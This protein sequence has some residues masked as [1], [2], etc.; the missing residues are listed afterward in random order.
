MK[1]KTIGI[2][3][4]MGPLA[5]L[6]FERKLLSMVEAKK[7]QDYPTIISFNDPSIPDRTEALKGRG[8]SPLQKL[9]E[10]AVKLKN[11]GAEVIC[12]P[13]NTA[14]AYLPALMS[15]VAGVEFVDM[16]D[17]TISVIERLRV[18]R[19]GVL[20]TDGTRLSR[21]YDAAL[22]KRG[23]T[24][25]YPN[26]DEQKHLVMDAIYGPTGIKSGN[27]FTGRVLLEQA[28]KSL[29]K[30]GAQCVVLGCTEIAMA[31]D[32]GEVPYLDT[33]AILAKTA[34]DKADMTKSESLNHSTV[35]LFARFRG[36]S[37]SNPL[38]RAT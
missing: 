34:L 30:N 18:Q 29:V 24:S 38:V 3:G 23:L 32:T 22:E 20:C 13:C 35:T 10:N 33:S 9:I 7:D 31:L 2:L 6:D 1:Y 17:A 36:L 28:A 16:I 8:E 27:M 4:G 25:I 19:V 21:V 11:S 26:H 14:H 37:G 5:T 15:F 12:M